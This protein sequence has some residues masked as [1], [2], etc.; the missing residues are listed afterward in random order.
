VCASTAAARYAGVRPARYLLH[1]MFLPQP[2]NEGR[3]GAFALRLEYADD[4]IDLIVDAHAVQSHTA[5]TLGRCHRFDADWLTAHSDAYCNEIVATVKRD[6]P[7]GSRCQDRRVDSASR[8]TD[9][10]ATLVTNVVL[11]NVEPTTGDIILGLQGIDPKP[12]GLQFRR[13]I[14]A[15]VVITLLGLMQRSREQFKD[16]EGEGLT[17][18]QTL[19]LTGLRRLQLPDG[20]L[21]MVLEFENGLPVAVTVDPTAVPALQKELAEIAK[22]S[23]RPS[24]H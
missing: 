8:R 24:R 11:A 6:A 9:R 2:L 1:Q 19:F 5:G 20:R 18:F 10:M 17:N 13:G 22:R 4:T 23:T 14:V 3:S 16:I 15:N 7:V 12:Y 21:G